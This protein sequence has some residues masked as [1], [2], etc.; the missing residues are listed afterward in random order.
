MAVSNYQSDDSGNEEVDCTE[1][2]GGS[3][4]ADKITALTATFVGQN[5][6]QVYV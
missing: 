4:R 3:I 6:S 2:D 5:F 1:D